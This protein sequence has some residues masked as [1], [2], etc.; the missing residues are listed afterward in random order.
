MCKGQRWW[1]P[2]CIIGILLVDASGLA[3]NQKIGVY[4]ASTL[5]RTGDWEPTVIA[6]LLREH[7][8]TELLQLGQSY[9][10]TDLEVTL[11]PALVIYPFHLTFV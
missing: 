5:N 2:T 11:V 10:T 1:Q 6:E 7:H 9:C 4:A 3:R 8:P